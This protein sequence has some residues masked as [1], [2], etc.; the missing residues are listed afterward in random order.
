MRIELTCAHCGENHFRLD[1]AQADDSLISC[2]ECGHLVGSLGQ[3]KQQVAEQVLA[4][5]KDKSAF[6][7]G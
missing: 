5:S 3:L 4:S 1:E 7:F 2:E 6:A